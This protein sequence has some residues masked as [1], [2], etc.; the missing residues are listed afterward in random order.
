MNTISSKSGLKNN[1]IAGY[2]TL[3]SQPWI[4]RDDFAQDL[5]RLIRILVLP[6]VDQS[7]SLMH[8]DEL[9]AECLA[10]I[11]QIL[12]AG[13]LKKCQTRGK[14]FGFI[15]TALQ[16]HLR[17]LVQRHAF[18]E[19]RTGI[20]PPPKH[21]LSTSEW[22]DQRPT[23]P[24]C[25]SLNDETTTIQVGGLDSVFC[26]A[27]FLEELDHVLTPEERDVL[28]CLM[29]QQDRGAGEG[30]PDLPDKRLS[31]LVLNIRSKAR[32]ILRGACGH[33]H[34]VVPVSD[35]FLIVK[36]ADSSHE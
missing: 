20:K 31:L 15:K 9:R 36:D 33:D 10:K 14:A 18:T 35:G 23:K 6:Y 19:K 7:N 26:Q 1:A 17:S 13:H 25:I 12:H 29:R 16:N 8:D 4:T 32:A 30:S 22:C 3:A 34:A 24:R 2:D 5:D 28:E 27:E 11:A 21:R